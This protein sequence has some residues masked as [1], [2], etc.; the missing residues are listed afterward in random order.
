ML[1]NVVESEDSV[2]YIYYFTQVWNLMWNEMK[3][4][5]LKDRPLPAGI[6][7]DDEFVA[8][9]R[10]MLYVLFSCSCTSDTQEQKWRAISFLLCSP[11]S[12]RVLRWCFKEARMNGEWTR[13]W[14]KWMNE[15]VQEFPFTIENQVVK[16]FTHFPSS[17]ANHFSESVF[18]CWACALQSRVHN[19]RHLISRSL[20]I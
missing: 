16:K 4:I 9:S 8:R 11:C 17:L 14:M 2:F 5:W 1:R 6:S 12:K 10:D 13:E 15:S 19:T 7:L 18:V 20:F 3:V